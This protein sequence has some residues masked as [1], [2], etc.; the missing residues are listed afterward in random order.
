MIKATEEELLDG[1]TGRC[2]ACGAEAHGVEPD[3]R[4]YT[5]DRCGMAKVYG[6]HELLLMDELTIIGDDDSE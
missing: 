1:N 5:C 4:E 6:L 2:L 3:A